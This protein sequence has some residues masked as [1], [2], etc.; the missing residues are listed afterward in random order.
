MQP[1][2]GELCLS[3][4]KGHQ[5]GLLDKHCLPRFSWVCYWFTQTRGAAIQV[6]TVDGNSVL[7]VMS[8]IQDHLK[9]QGHHT[10]GPLTPR[11]S[12]Q[13]SNLREHKSVRRKRKEKDKRGPCPMASPFI[14]DQ[15]ELQRTC[16]STS[17]RN[18]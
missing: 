8:N 14:T 9:G 7:P 10:W 12:L 6:I 4:L 17:K 2:F 16:G 15:F 5:A 1:S 13:A 3:K 18:Q 11:L